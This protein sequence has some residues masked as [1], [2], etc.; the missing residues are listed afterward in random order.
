MTCDR[1]KGLPV[2][3]GGRGP[4]PHPAA[5]ADL[6]RLWGFPPG[7]PPGDDVQHDGSAWI[8]G[9]S[10]AADLSRYVRR[11]SRVGPLGAGVCAM[12]SGFGYSDRVRVVRELRRK[13]N[14]R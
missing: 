9:R 13:V 7:R 11:V 5:C 6:A 4:C 3:A 2:P 10:S 8:G 1:C 14:R 12:R